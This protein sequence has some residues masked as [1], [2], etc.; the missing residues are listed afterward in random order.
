MNG[1]LEL[2]R[3]TIGKKVVM[4]LS[5]VVWFGYVIGHL[6]GNLQVYAGP[7]KINAYAEFLHQTPALLW[8]TRVLLLFAILAHIVASTELTLR[9]LSARP[10]AY[11]RKQ[12]LATDYAARTMIWS[13]P[14]ILLFIL[15]HLL[16]LTF[17]VSPDF[18]YDPHDVYNNIVASF[19]IRWLSACYIAAQVALGAHLYHGAW[20]FL[21]TL[22][23][24]HPE[25]NAV[26][27]T[28]AAAASALI[29]AG[30]VSIP[31]SVMAGVLPPAPVAAERA[32]P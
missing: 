2:Y 23:V 22:G 9:N 10:I 31:I 4:A 7:A 1:P 21:Q 24:N 25:Y 27:R 30:F 6:L 28:V 32:V 29:V 20:S 17:G 26:R 8:G 13:G 19:R 15:Y 3:T 16:N 18:A 14:I 5:G 12:D 11:A